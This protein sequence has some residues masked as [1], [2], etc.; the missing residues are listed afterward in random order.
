MNARIMSSTTCILK[1]STRRS[2]LI[3]HQTQNN[4]QMLYITRYSMTE[5]S[6]ILLSSNYSS[7]CLLN[8]NGTSSIRKYNLENQLHAQAIKMLK[9]LCSDYNVKALC[10]RI[11]T[12][13]YIDHLLLPIMFQIK[14]L[15]N[16]AHT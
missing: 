5:N 3:N 10:I 6:Q 12:C 1:F 11:Q 2:N 15:F 7:D 14:Y 13:A 16:N 9:P 8:I 4:L